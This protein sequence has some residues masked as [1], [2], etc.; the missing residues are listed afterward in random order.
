MG[1][2]ESKYFQKWIS[3]KPLSIAV[4]YMCICYLYI[5]VYIHYICSIYSFKYVCVGFFFIFPSSP[6]HLIKIIFF[7]ISFHF[8]KSL[9]QLIEKKML[10]WFNNVNFQ[11][12]FCS[13]E[14][15]YKESSGMLAR[16]CS[17]AKEQYQWLFIQAFNTFKARGGEWE[18][19]LLYQWSCPF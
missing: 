11:E 15:N 8:H 19:W 14:V 10:K 5:S 16:K 2:S 4:I 18:K 7:L 1:F 13:H 17:W 9:L 12:V 6:T 3:K